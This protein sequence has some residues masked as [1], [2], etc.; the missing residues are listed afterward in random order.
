M[1]DYQGF[2]KSEAGYLASTKLNAKALLIDPRLD[3]I[4]SNF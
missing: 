4:T 1:G 3:P 2:D